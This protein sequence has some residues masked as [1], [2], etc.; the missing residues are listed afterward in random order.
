MNR[1]YVT[2]K[3]GNKLKLYYDTKEEIYKAWENE[4]KSVVLYED[5]EYLNDIEYIKLNSIF[6]GYDNYNRECYKKQLSDG[7]LI[8]RLLKD[9]TDDLYYDYCEYQFQNSKSVLVPITYTMGTPTDIVEQFFMPAAEYI[10]YSKRYYGQPKLSKP[11]ELSKIKQSFSVDFIPKKC[12][13][14]CFIND[15][16]L[17][18]KHRDYFS[19]SYRKPEDVGMPL[20]YKLK[21]YSIAQKKEK[22]IYS[23]NWGSIVL[24]NESWLCFKNIMPIIL[25]NK[26]AHKV[27]LDLMI[28][29]DENM[30]KNNDYYE[31]LMEWERFFEKVTD[32][33]RNYIKKNKMEEKL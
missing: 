3:D 7:N 17:W 9:K 8:I 29:N 30:S 19:S 16:D 14:A 25:R 15:N 6:L 18:I 20:S 12:A 13:C 23:D 27:M 21:K 32:E 33:C 31:M 26:N 4:V 10:C 1:W 22:F 2:L 24:R 28:Q 11:K 5:F